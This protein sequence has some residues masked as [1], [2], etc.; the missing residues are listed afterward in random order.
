M[1]TKYLTI[2]FI[3]VLNYLMNNYKKYN[4]KLTT[5]IVFEQELLSFQFFTPSIIY[6]TEIY[7]FACFFVKEKMKHI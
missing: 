6:L 4:S 2:T 3:R 1:K 5:L 7:I